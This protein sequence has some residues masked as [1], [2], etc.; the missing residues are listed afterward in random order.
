MRDWPFTNAPVVAQYC[1][2]YQG[3]VV[4]S[5]PMATITAYRSNKKPYETDCPMLEENRTDD[6]MLDL[7]DS[8]GHPWLANKDVLVS[9]QASPP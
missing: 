2:P 8:A 5:A 4:S 3:I 1:G 7:I 6:E 9:V